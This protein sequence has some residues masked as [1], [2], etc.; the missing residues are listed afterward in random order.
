MEGHLGGAGGVVGKRS[1]ARVEE[2]D[3]RRVW[4]SDLL[5]HA[6]SHPEEVR[7]TTYGASISEFG[8]DNVVETLKPKPVS[9]DPFKLM[10]KPELSLILID[11]MA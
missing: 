2:G 11:L 6:C 1:W 7:V 5:P 3:R 4:Q 9:C 8:L 10:V